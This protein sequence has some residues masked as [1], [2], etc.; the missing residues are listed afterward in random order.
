[1]TVNVGHDEYFLYWFRSG[2]QS[3]WANGVAWIITDIY[4]WDW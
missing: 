4:S 2:W 1:M 3:C